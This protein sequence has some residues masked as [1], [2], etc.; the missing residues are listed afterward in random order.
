MKN[1]LSRRD[2]LKGAAAGSLGL[3]MAG[4][5]GCSS[6]SQ[7]TSAAPS[8][9]TSQAE[10][11]STN[12]QAGL[13]KPGTY[14]STVNGFS[15][16]ITVDMTFSTDAI[17]DCMIN[18]GGETPNIGGVA[19]TEMAGLIVSNQSVD[20]TTSASATIT[21]A[22]IKKAAS[23]CI[24]QAQGTASALNERVDENDTDW[25]GTAPEIDD[26]LI[27]SV[28]DTSLLIV[29]AGS[30]GMIAAATAADAGM[31]F[32]I[33]EQNAKPCDCRWWIGAV[34]S[35]HVK[36]AGLTVDKNRLMNELGRYASYKCD[37][38]VIKVWLDYSGEMV[39]YL[40]SL[41][42][43]VMINP[44]PTTH[45]GG[46]GMEYYVPTTWH[47][48]ATE[49][50]FATAEMPFT[51]GDRNKVLEKHINS[52]GY[53]I[54]YNMTLVR[55]VQNETGKVTGAIF[56]NADGAYVKVNADNV[57]LATGGYAG[58]PKMVKAL[59]PIANETVT[60]NFFYAPNKGMGIRA[61][62]WAGGVKSPEPA[63]MIFDRG[64]VAP[65]VKAGY[66]DDGN[67]G[68]TFPSSMDQFILGSQPYLKV[69]KEGERFMNESLPYDFQNF[70]AAFQTD[71]VFACIMD[72]NVTE[73]I[74]AYDQYGCAKVGM[75]LAHA[76]AVIPTLE[77]CIPQGLVFKADTIEDLAV[78]L[79]IPAD[80]LRATVDR[81]NDLAAKGKDEDFGK[82][83][84][85][86]RPI[87]K[88]PFYGYFLG[89]TLFT[90]MD[91]LRINRKC[92]VYVANRQLIEGLYSVGDCSGS[93]FSGNYPEFIVGAALG[94]T[95]TQGRYAVKA[96]LGEEF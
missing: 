46:E 19:A 10:T 88:A 22:A 25:L 91:G 71:G 72:S 54:S 1:N 65:G 70:N 95:L 21:V 79:G 56:A 4:L 42:M 63:P 53:Q 62:I 60:S 35:E 37:L 90:T 6:Q 50:E 80:T 96:I 73:D 84:Y 51:P 52:K 38:D 57:I 26:T 41:G 83:A 74:L 13:Y 48:I 31:D 3:A 77:S 86:M 9:S 17:T 27:S 45:V 76:G 47:T 28:L 20:V 14:S 11:T 89:G 67:G 12:T 49:D 7:T 23:N 40:E 29:G 15:G 93:Y 55:L 69:N 81:Y 2:F 66:I 18:A 82:E 16:Y 61:G 5:V 59:T 85:R 58:N 24:A 75:L 87:V 8:E 36:Q 34:N 94:R 44:A 78:Q 32:M 39:S 43:K 30:S 33:C 92:Q 68:L 64:I